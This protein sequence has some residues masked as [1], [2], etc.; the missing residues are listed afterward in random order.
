MGSAAVVHGGHAR[1]RK[2]LSLCAAL[3]A[4]AI[5]GSGALAA[6]AS[7][8]AAS[9]LGS[10]G[11]ALVETA[12]DSALHGDWE[13][14]AR[15][16]AA[17][18]E[19]DET[20]SDALHL[21]AIVTLKRRDDAGAALAFCEAA[22]AQ[23]RF[24]LYTAAGSLDLEGS[25]LVRLHRYADCLTLLASAQDAGA[26]VL[27]P[28]R[29]LLRA[30]SFMGQGR[31]ADAI[32]ELRTA[33]DRFPSDKDFP[34]LFFER[35]SS[36]P[37][38][39]E[40]RALGDL[41]VR[42]LSAL[43]TADQELLVLA[44][45]FILDA[46]Q[47]E[48][49]IRAFRAQ[50]GS[51]A[52]ATIEAL[53]YGIIGDEAALAEL[54]SGSYAL[55]LADLEETEGL[56]GTAAGRKRLAVLLSSFSGTIRADRDH[57]G[58]DEESVVYEKGALSAWKRDADQ[59]G[60]V[61]AAVAFHEGF[62]SGS[63][64]RRGDELITIGYGTYPYAV[65]ITY[66]R[67]P[68][69]RSLAS[70]VLSGSGLD[71]PAEELYRFAP[72]AFMVK[73]LFFKAF[74]SATEPAIFL[75]E[76]SVIPPPLRQ[77]A[78]SAALL[79]ELVEAGQRDLVYLDHGIPQRRLR[80]VDGRLYADLSYSAGRPGIEKLDSDGDGRFETERA[81]RDGSDPAELAWIRVDADG[82]GLFEY[83]EDM[84]FPFRKEWDLDRNG[85]VDAVERRTAEGGRILEFSSGLDGILD[86]VIVID[87][88]GATVSVARKGRV[89]IMVPDANPS[90]S[91]IGRKEF[92]LGSNVPASEGIY[93]YMN[94]RYRLVYSGKQ[95]YAELLP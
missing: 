16:L 46:R 19:V 88:S 20:N 51:S 28:S 48:D 11:L 15:V 90:V 77:A 22:R 50:G 12:R 60:S 49:S 34:R 69:V 73:P 92:D 7:P 59:D 40:A 65:Q 43:A 21:A 61:D 30:L 25:L 80:F 39:S 24:T 53:R 2:V 3:F 4:A 70:L 74:P 37:P 44:V 81:Y 86:E 89:S 35:F 10:R 47:R 78:A 36:E 84:T 94:R 76:P 56:L 33:A 71:A 62:P 95:A 31:M 29:Y 52:R 85:S 83:H 57:D 13:G 18:L 91:W 75:P 41:F 14:A 8:G 79:V 27:D 6:Q 17:A 68:S 38:D 55:R 42:R 26:A 1:G 54:F 72:E 66:A 93:T 82:D 32:R 5:S 45:P 23:G 58:F 87:G 63:M 9:G 67:T 64:S